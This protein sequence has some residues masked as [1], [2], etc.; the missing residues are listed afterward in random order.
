MICVLLLEKRHWQRSGTGSENC[1]RS[2]PKYL[3][4]KC[5]KLNWRTGCRSFSRILTGQELV[6]HI[7]I[8]STAW[9]YSLMTMWSSSSFIAIWY[10]RK[11]FPPKNKFPSYLQQNTYQHKGLAS[12]KKSKYD[13]IM[14]LPQSGK[15][16]RSLF[17]SC[18]FATSF[19][20]CRIKVRWSVVTKM[21]GKYHDCLPV[22][23]A[24]MVRY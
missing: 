19:L 1:S 23:Q 9:L 3:Q 15:M 8:V 12:Y 13:K 21:I 18:F 2:S 10:R 22:N 24:M 20:C 5:L 4:G 11:L 17:S 7:I 16:Q 6:L 14:R